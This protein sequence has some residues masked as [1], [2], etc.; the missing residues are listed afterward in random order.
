MRGL[1]SSLGGIPGLRKELGKALRG[2]SAL[3]PAPSPLALQVVG[4]RGE[5]NA[6][7]G[8]ATTSTNVKQTGRSRHYI[9]TQDVADLR[10][11][12]NGFFVDAATSGNFQTCAELNASNDYTLRIALEVNGVSKRMTFN[13]GQLETVVAAGSALVLTD[14][15]LPSE[16]GLQAFPAQQEIWVRAEREFVVGQKGMFHQTAS[17][18]PTITGESYFVGATS[19]T[20]RLTDTG[21]LSTTGGW[22]Q[23]AHVWLPYCI[24]GTPKK[25]MLAAAT[26]GASIENGVNDGQ[27]DGLNGAGGY[28]RRMLANV[29][30]KKVARIHLAKSGETVKSFV[31]NSAKRRQMLQYVNHV[32]SGHGGND[33]STSETL[34]NTQTRWTTAW[35]Y[36]KAFGAFV[37]HFA[38][39]PKTNSTDWSTLEGQTPRAGFEVGG[40]WRDAGNTWCAGQVAADP[41]LDQFID[42][43][44]VQTA[45]TARDKWR[46]DLGQPTTD[47]THPN[48]VIAA[49]MATEAAGQIETLRAS[50]E[51]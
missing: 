6:I 49:A 30:G 32:F 35:G 28:M 7:E 29:S 19:A 36:M 17:N 10:V 51:T 12:F 2:S 42:L 8:G 34:A 50:W 13:G 23:Q 26:F 4:S 31:S 25:K 41:N 22:T 27:G 38:L 9:G 37:T 48:A 46:I 14:P 21:A 44:N 40:A 1:R 47:G 11:G 15:I 3:T 16:F 45:V 24:L 43:G 33:Y 20:S 5:I 18:N 39:S